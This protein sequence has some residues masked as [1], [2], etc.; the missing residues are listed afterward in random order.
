MINNQLG[1]GKYLIINITTPEPGRGPII[2][3]RRENTRATGPRPVNI[4]HNNKE[5]ANGFSPWTKLGFS[6]E[7]GS[8]SVATHFWTGMSPREIR[9]R[10]DDGLQVEGDFNPVCV[11][12]R[13]CA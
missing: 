11:W 4:L 7:L 1:S 13:L 6:Y 10:R 8:I 5:L 3:I 12:A 9:S 2:R